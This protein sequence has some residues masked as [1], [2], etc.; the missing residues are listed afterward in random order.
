MGFSYIFQHLEDV[1]PGNH[2]RTRENGL[3]LCQ[4]RLRMD[5]SRNLSME[6]GLDPHPWR[7]LGNVALTAL[8]W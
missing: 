3:K 2:D 5:I 1:A 7:I 6:I 8:G 4:E